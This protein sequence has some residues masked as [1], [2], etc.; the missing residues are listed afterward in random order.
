MGLTRDVQ[1]NSLLRREPVT[2]AVIS[3]QS[4]AAVTTTAYNRQFTEPH[5]FRRI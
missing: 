2:C 4:K 3:G 1:R 5:D